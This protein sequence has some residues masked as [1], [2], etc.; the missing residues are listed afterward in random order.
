LTRR[1]AQVERFLLNM[2]TKLAWCVL[3]LIV[4]RAHSAAGAFPGRE[5][6]S[7]VESAIEVV[8]DRTSPR[9]STFMGLGIEFD[10][11]QKQPAATKWQTILDRVRTMRPGFL[12]VMSG[13]GDYCLGFDEKGSPIYVW[14]HHD[15]T[16]QKNLNKLLAILDFAQKEKFDVFLGE[17]SPRRG[18]GIEDPGDPRW[19]RIIADFVQYLVRQRHY[20]VLRHYIFFNEPNG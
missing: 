17:W 14:D 20:S 9:L 19:A 7:S 12:R 15:P 11:Y 13:A 4:P 3:I 2:R 5:Q 18:I 16:A 8:V 10:P 1:F 6:A